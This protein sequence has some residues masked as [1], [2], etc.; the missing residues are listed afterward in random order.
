MPQS[1]ENYSINALCT[2]SSNA[3]SRNGNIYVVGELDGEEVLSSAEVL[4]PNTDQWTFIHCLGDALSGIS[5]VAYSNCP[6]ALGGY[7]GFTILISGERYNASCSSDWQQISEMFNPRSN[8]A[9]VI[10]DSM[11]CCHWGI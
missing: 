5:L 3:A 11:I 6:Y 7:N 8:F 4:D 9:A 10:R 2:I 1:V